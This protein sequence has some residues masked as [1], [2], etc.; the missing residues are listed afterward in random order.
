MKPL[1]SSWALLFAFAC[2]T[3]RPSQAPNAA[4]EA[5]AAERSRPAEPRAL[6]W[7]VRRPGSAHKLYLTGSIHLAQP[8]QISFPPSLEAAFAGASALVVE[9]DTDRADKR[10]MQALVMELGLY[11]PPG[12][13][14]SGH[15]SEETLALLPA[16]LARVGLKPANVEPMR[17]WLLFVTLT[18]LEL[19]KAGFS[20]KGGIDHLLLARARGTKRIVELETAEDQLRSLALIAPEA[21][22]LALREVIQTGPLMSV[23][24][25]QMITAWEGGNADALAEKIFSEV[26][27]P[28]FA[29]MYEALYFQRN[30]AMA[31]KLAALVDGPQTHFAVV[32]AG[33]VVGPQGIPALLAKQGFEV[34]QLPRA[35]AVEPAGREEAAGATAR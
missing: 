31:E 16:A 20:E 22:D 28:R 26:N 17:P 23:S 35:G 21:A 8:D 24:F 18:V 19:Q 33:H 4:F 14:L 11:R 25:A 6:L 1:R 34:R 15:L 12:P 27:D 2:A 32:G 29:P 9:L 3:P 7:E 5:P 13:G 30:R 10:Q